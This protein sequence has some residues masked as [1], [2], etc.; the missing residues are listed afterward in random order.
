MAEVEEGIL[1]EVGPVDVDAAGELVKRVG[2]HNQAKLLIKSVTDNFPPE[3]VAAGS[4]RLQGGRSQTLDLAEVRDAAKDAFPDY[5]ELLSAKVRGSEDRPEKMVV[6]VVCRS[7]SGRSFRGIIAYDEL[8]KSKAAYEEAVKAGTITIRDDDPESVAKALEKAQR[9][10]VELETGDEG[11]GAPAGPPEPF[12]GYSDLKAADLVEKIEDGDYNLSTLVAIRDF[13]EAGKPRETV[14]EAASGLIERAE[15][16]LDEPVGD[17]E[18]FEG[19]ADIGGPDL[20]KAIEASDYDLQ[21]LFAIRTAETEGKQ[22]ST[23]EKAVTEKIADAEAA[24]K[25]SGS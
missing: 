12:T 20:V 1:R 21:T 11:D 5:V 10:I 6:N 22:R 19:Y 23:V 8:S 16:A 7:E 14:V 17:E 13:E 15:A 2:V 4:R 25:S 9:R 18:P 3:L 24:I